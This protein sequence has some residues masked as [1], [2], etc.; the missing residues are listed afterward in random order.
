VLSANTG[1]QAL[2][3]MSGA[4]LTMAL[5]SIIVEIF[6]FMMY[7][8][9]FWGKRIGANSAFGVSFLFFYIGL[10]SWLLVTGTGTFSVI[11]QMALFSSASVDL[12]AFQQLYFNLF[13]AP[14]IEE[15]FFRISMPVFLFLLFKGMFDSFGDIPVLTSDWFHVGL[16]A[17]VSSIGFA[18]FHT[19][20]ISTEGFVVQAFIFGLIL[21]VIF[22]SDLFYNVIKGV[23]V[24]PAFLVGVHVA[25]NLAYFGIGKALSVMT[26]NLFG[27]TILGLAFF[28]FI[29]ALN[30]AYLVVFG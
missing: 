11:D 15:N 2:S 27:W 4:F 17:V 10:F 30:E 6:I 18:V 13:V 8:F 25:N 23:T 21:S 16:S 19:N 28:T 5:F 3:S 26:G 14:F 20:K 29:V 22:L 9:R 12:S 7:D 1:N 24:V